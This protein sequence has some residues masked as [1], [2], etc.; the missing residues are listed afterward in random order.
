MNAPIAPPRLMTTEDLLA[1]P[2]DGAER[3]LIRGQLRERRPE[4]PEMT[5]R[6]RTH[7]AV[8]ANVVFVLKRWLHQQPRPRGRVYSG[9]AGCR[10]HRD[11][12]TTV[13]VDVVYF[14][15]EQVAQQPVDT[16]LLEGAPVLV[17]EILSPSGTEEQIN[18]KV[19]AYLGV[20]VPLVWLIDP[21]FRTVTVYRPDAEPSLFNVTQELSAEPHLPGFQVRVA[22]LF[23][24]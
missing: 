5:Y 2:D 17:V 10:L 4:G 15:A 6:N 20:G 14:T 3:W 11:P 23:D 13:G 21:Y 9:E 8:E 24:D 12:D 19:A 16:T 1:L 18:E 22:E 7:S